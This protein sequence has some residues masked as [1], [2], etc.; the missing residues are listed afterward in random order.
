MRAPDGSSPLFAGTAAYRVSRYWPTGPRA[1]SIEQP[2]EDLPGFP[3][4]MSL[5][6]DGLPW[7][8]IAAPRNA[9]LDRLLPLPGVLRQLVW[10]LP[11]ALRPAAARDVPSSEPMP[12]GRRSRGVPAV[13]RAVRTR[14]PCGPAARAPH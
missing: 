7:I 6:S 1:G 14:R 8:G 11:D 5:G 12:P 2:V 10:N 4:N 9:L 13:S 3:D